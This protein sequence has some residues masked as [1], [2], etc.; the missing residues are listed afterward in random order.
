M[1]GTPARFLPS[2][3]PF[4][5]EHLQQ[6]GLRFWP[7][8]LSFSLDSKLLQGSSSETKSLP[9]FSLHRRVFLALCKSL[10]GGLNFFNCS[11]GWGGNAS[12]SSLARVPTGSA[13]GGDGGWTW[14]RSFSLWRAA[15]V[16]CDGLSQRSLGGRGW[17]SCTATISHIWNR[18]SES[19]GLE[20]ASPF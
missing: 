10:Q 4:S 17:M 6:G 20:L 16:G 7:Q 18:Y 8:R 9:F 14:R 11:W 15:P 19:L 5:G 12:R 3:L 2:F 1:S 13:R